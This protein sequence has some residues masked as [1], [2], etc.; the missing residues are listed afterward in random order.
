MCWHFRAVALA[1]GADNRFQI[2]GWGGVDDSVLWLSF[3]QQKVEL[4][5]PAQDIG[6]VKKIQNSML[7]SAMVDEKAKQV[8]G[9]F[10]KQMF[11]PTGKVGAYAAQMSQAPPLRR[12]E[13][14]RRRQLVPTLVL[15][16]CPQG[17]EPSFCEMRS[18]PGL[19]SGP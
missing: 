8:R 6:R 18:P 5:L 3:A 12:R 10:F 9:Q 19:S 4:F 11:A 16:N 14:A 7:A 2:W 13:L 15:K 17:S 1:H